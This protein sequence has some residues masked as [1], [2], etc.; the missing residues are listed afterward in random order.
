MTHG[1]EWHVLDSAFAGADAGLS[2]PQRRTESGGAMLRIENLDRSLPPGYAEG[3]VPRRTEF[4][5]N[6]VRLT[7]SPCMP[8]MDV[9]CAV[10]GFDPA[11]SPIRWRLVCRHV[12]CRHTN[13][14]QYRYRSACQPLEREWRG[15]SRA[16]AFTLFDEASRECSCTYNAR[17]R[18]LGGHA[19]LTVAAVAGPERLVDYVHLRIAG[20][21]PS[22]ADVFAYL[23]SQLAGWDANIMLM[24]RAIFRHESSFSQFAAGAQGSA[25]MTFGRRHHATPGQPDCRV[26]FDWPDDPSGFPLASF[27]FGVGIA[28]FTQIGTQTVSPEIAWDWRE[29]IRLG[30]N[31]FLG[32]LRRQ[33]KSGMT[34]RHWALDAWRAYNGSGASA[35]RYAM[36]LAMSDDGA[37]IPLTAVAAAPLIAMIPP[38]DPLPDAGPWLLA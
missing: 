34:W 11:S 20:T 21:N 31:L 4:N 32:K 26:R 15:E 38:A 28:Q 16:P 29:N 10:A 17:S 13:V 25:A 19:I 27:D 24:L 3:G 12:L 9:R 30:T 22:Q 23:D 33:Y 37:R 6:V 1:P 36:Q 14:G 2:V 18:V 7:S 8:L 35:E 5:A